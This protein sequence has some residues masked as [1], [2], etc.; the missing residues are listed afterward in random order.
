MNSLILPFSPFTPSVQLDKIERM[1]DKIIQASEIS[2]Y[3]YCRRAWWLKRIH[4]HRPENVRELTAGSDYHQV[5]GY[6][7]ERAQKVRLLAYALLGIALMT[8]LIW[9]ISL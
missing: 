8:A 6:M 7:V 2:D 1:S 5:H 9:W 4:G 3:I